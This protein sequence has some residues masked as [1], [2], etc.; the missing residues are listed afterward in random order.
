M[1]TLLDS[2]TSFRAELIELRA[3]RARHKQ[4]VRE[5]SAYTSIADRV[6]IETIVARY[7]EEETVEVRQI[8]AGAS[9]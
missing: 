6:E 9:A 5:L 4:L 7:P 8:L 3:A 1:N 2:I